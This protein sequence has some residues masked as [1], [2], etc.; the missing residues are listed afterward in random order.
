MPVIESPLRYPGGKTFLYNYIKEIMEY[1]NFLGY[2][3]LEPFAGGAGIAIKLLL[4]NEVKQIIINDFDIAIYA[5]WYSILNYTKKFCDKI[6]NVNIN[7]EEWYIQKKIY[8]DRKNSNLLELGFA[9]F[10]LNRTNISG[11]ITG[12]VIGGKYQSGKYKIDSRFNKEKLIQKIQN[13]AAQKDRIL[14]Y[15]KDAIELLNDKSIK[16][17][18]NIFINFDPPYFFKGKELYT[19]FY[20]KEDHIALSNTIKEIRNEWVLTYDISDFIYSLYSQYRM[21]NINLYHNINKKKKSEEYI[22]FSNDIL[23]PKTINV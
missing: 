10:F 21:S 9:T 13:I 8:K 22:F 1:N 4:K 14:L 12:G 11:I 20:K 19:N 3:Y 7:L 17:N 18:K 2:S 15:N 6:Y 23:L 5:F 16:N